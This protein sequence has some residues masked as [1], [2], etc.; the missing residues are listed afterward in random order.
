MG[1]YIKFSDST[2]SSSREDSINAV[3]HSQQIWK[4]MAQA[5]IPTTPYSRA[6]LMNTLDFSNDDPLLI[7]QDFSRMQKW[8]ADRLHEAEK[9]IFPH[10][11]VEDKYMDY[12]ACK[13]AYKAA[14]L[15]RYPN[16]SPELIAAVLR[17]EQHFYKV[18]DAT[19]D[20]EAKDRGTVLK[21]GK[22]DSM[23]SI[24]PAQMQIKKIRELVNA[25]NATSH[26]PKFPYLSHMKDDPIREALKPLNAALLAGAYF[27]QSA[28]KLKDVDI[29]VNDK[30]LAYTYNADVFTRDGRYECPSSL[31][32]R[33]ESKLPGFMK[34]HRES[35][36]LPKSN[37]VL[38][39][40][41]HVKNVQKQLTYIKEHHLLPED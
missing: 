7:A 9:N 35:V 18:T 6:R 37:E 13:Q 2:Q 26:E 39:I 5:A 40:S 38:T 10:M 33:A 27:E 12:A 8:G 15:E 11:G 28:E 4:D 17:N 21:D 31:E 1:D 16:V 3:H 34:A 24:G 14:H 20:K 23:A 30:T 29:P 32:V 41:T 25:S 19:Q 22:E 36:W